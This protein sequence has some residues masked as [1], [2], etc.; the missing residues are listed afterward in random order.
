V[1]YLRTLLLL[2]A[3]LG[4][5]VALVPT[6]GA[7]DDR[8]RV[9]AIEFENDVNPVTADYVTDNIEKA[10]KEG[11]DAVVI[12]LDTPGGLAEAMRDIYKRML[13]SPL[14]VIVYVSPDGARAAS[15]GVWIVQAGDIAAMAPQ[16]NIGSSTPI[17]L[18]GEDIQKDLRNKVVNDAAKSLRS[19]AETHGRNV[20]WAERAVRQAANLTA[21]EALEQNVIDEIAPNLDA[22]LEQ[23]DGQTT[24]GT[25][26]IVLDTAG[27]DVDTVDM[28]LWTRI[29]DTI[30]DPNIITLL[31]SLG[32]LAI[33]VELFN[34]GLIFPAAF[35]AISLII[36]LFGLQ[37]LPF[38]WA[39]ILLMLVAFGFFIAEAFVASHGAL[40]FAGA[41]AFVFGALLLFDPAGEAY[42]VSLP[43]AIAIGAAL[44]LLI[45]FAIAKVIAARRARP[46]TGTEEL[47]GQVG[48]VREALA[49]E[50]LVFLHGEI[51]RARS[52][53]GETIPVGAPIKVEALHEGLVL[54]VSP[55]E[56][57]VTVAD[58]ETG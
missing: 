6:A 53:G 19:L 46:R 26:E 33:T 28:P 36:G 58:G 50:G 30:V 42:Q 11:Y 47:L 51:W 12:L 22:L 49:P 52:A 38:S 2:A 10:E 41:V 44:A 29:L 40:A 17:S 18:G 7:Q 5:A 35:G 13:A 39:G 24:K 27:A 56:Q 3:S 16:T 54:D 55:L 31:L 1:R 15:A 21:T 23:I 9:L 34:P 57:P 8:P 4:A 37:V 48:A 45:G 14:P 43:V 20:D 32:V 25:K